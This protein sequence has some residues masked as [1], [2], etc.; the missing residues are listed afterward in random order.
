[1]QFTVTFRHM[2][3]TDALRGYAEKRVARFKKFFA[4]PISCHVT[5]STTRHHHTVDVNVQLHNGFRIAAHETTENMYS[6]IDIVAAKI[7][8]QVR[9]YKSKLRHRKVRDMPAAPVFHS[10]IHEPD[11]T[12]VNADSIADDSQSLPETEAP[13]IKSREKISAQPMAISEAVMQLNLLHTQ[14]YVFRNEDTAE[15]NIVYKHED[16]G[17]GLIETGKLSK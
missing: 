4:D 6:S 16:G 17:Y 3:G 9:R 5:M 11:S 14:F 10:R 13:A 1:M 8:R 2:E 12:P 7:E 15:V